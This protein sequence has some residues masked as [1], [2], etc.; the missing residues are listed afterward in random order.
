MLV[1]WFNDKQTNLWQT[2]VYFTSLVGQGSILLYLANVQGPSNE[3][4]AVK[5]AIADN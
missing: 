5:Q 3:L 4:L 1:Y 2:W